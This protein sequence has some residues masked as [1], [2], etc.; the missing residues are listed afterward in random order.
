MK[1]NFNNRTSLSKF[2]D[3]YHGIVT[4]VIVN[5]GNCLLS[6][7]NYTLAKVY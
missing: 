1:I 3:L 4:Q 2:Y 7:I 5:T 6:E